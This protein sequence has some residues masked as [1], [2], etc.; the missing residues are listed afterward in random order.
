MPKTIPQLNVVKEILSLPSNKRRDGVEIVGSWASGK[1]LMACQMARELG[2]SLLYITAGRIE[3]ETVFD[4]LCTFMEPGR[5]F[6]LP[7]WEVLPTDAM[8]PADDIVA[9]RMNALN[10][11]NQ[12]SAD[13]QPVY[14][15]LSVRSFRDA[16]GC[17]CRILDH[18]YI[19]QQ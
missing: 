17:L 8:E 1:A 9:E 14:L 7:A 18:H 15:S 12:A 19:R 2:K 5:S 6:M 10:A 3:S 13:K 16:E 4:D 11:L